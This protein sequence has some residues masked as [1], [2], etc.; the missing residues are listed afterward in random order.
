MTVTV[1]CDCDLVNYIKIET[2]QQL[3]QSLTESS[4]PSQRSDSAIVP[5]KQFFSFQ[6]SGLKRQ[7][8][9]RK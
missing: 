7:E 5:V 1:Y 4:C 2:Y 6:V 9:Q 8:M 3:E